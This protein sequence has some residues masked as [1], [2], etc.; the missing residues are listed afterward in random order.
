MGRQQGPSSK[1]LGGGCEAPSVDGSRIYAM[2]GQG[3]LICTDL[4]GRIQWQTSMN[5]LG[6]KT[7][8]WGYT[9]SVLVDGN[10]VIATPG[11]SQ[12][13]VAG[14]NKQTGQVAWR[15]EQFRMGPIF[16]GHR[17]Q[18]QRRPPVHPVDPTK[19]GWPRRPQR[20]C[21][22]EVLLARPHAVVPTPI[23]SNGK[24][25]SGYGVG[26]KVVN[27]G[28]SNRV[29]DVWQNK[30]MQNHHGGVI[31]LGQHVYG[32]GDGRGLVCQKLSD[33]EE[34][35]TGDRSLRKGA[36]TIADDMIIAVNESDGTVAVPTNPAAFRVAGNFACNHSPASAAAAARCGP[37]RWSPMVACICVIR[38][39]ST[40][41]SS[42]ATVLA[43]PWAK[44]AL[45]RPA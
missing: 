40:A 35:W 24:F 17:R 1:Q 45:G 18:S 39:T 6:G 44:P 43:A 28:A 27:I 8:G 22:L 25:S 4:N 38:N 26:C 16:L 29:R 41:T 34:V 12:G 5:R 33:G 3:N 42:A 31:R 13:A 2:G 19:R 32:F 11:G 7:P 10:L 20:Q 9:E 30:V 15:S 14:I 36:I 23:F 37:T 21:A